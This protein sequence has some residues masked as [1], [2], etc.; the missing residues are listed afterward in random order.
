MRFSARAR[1][2]ATAG[3]LLI[4]LTYSFTPAVNGLGGRR[5]LSESGRLTQA[6]TPTRRDARPV[7]RVPP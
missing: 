6:P 7:S 1:V 5:H 2:C 4:S 3:E